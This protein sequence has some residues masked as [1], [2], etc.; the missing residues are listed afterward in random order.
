MIKAFIVME[1]SA[2]F[3]DGKNE[4]GGICLWM[5]LGEAFGELERAEQEYEESNNEMPEFSVLE[6]EF[7]NKREILSAI[8]CAISG[9]HLRELTT[10]TIAVYNRKDME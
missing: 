4:L 1:K 5:T 7:T 6:I 9:N 2:E 10:K 8:E 3:L